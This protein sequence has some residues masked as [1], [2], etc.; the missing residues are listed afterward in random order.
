MV[1]YTRILVSTET[2]YISIVKNA[3]GYWEPDIPVKTESAQI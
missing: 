1:K 3:K 2:N